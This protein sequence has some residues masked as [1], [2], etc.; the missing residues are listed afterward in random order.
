MANF[1]FLKFKPEYA[2]FASGCIEAEKVYHTSPAMCAIGCRKALELGVKWVYGAES[3]PMP[4]QDTL[5][6][7][8]HDPDFRRIVD[9]QVWEMFRYVI[10][11][12]NIAV[13]SNSAMGTVSKY[14]SGLS[15]SPRKIDDKS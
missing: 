11:L 9:R 5:Q 7:L 12:G 10:R 6:A 15:S 2:L 4:Y 1:D 13:H 3:L 8:I 14:P